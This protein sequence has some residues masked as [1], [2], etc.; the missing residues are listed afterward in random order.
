[1]AEAPPVVSV[2]PTR[3]TLENY[4]TSYMGAYLNTISTERPEHLPPLARSQFHEIE[5]CLMPNGC[6]AMLFSR[7]DKQGVT[8]NERD[9]NY[10]EG[11]VMSG[12]SHLVAVY[13]HEGITVADAISRGKRDASRDVRSLEDSDIAKA[14]SQLEK[15]V[16]GLDEI[17]RQN[18]GTLSAGE[19]ELEKLAP[20]KD[21]L[22]TAGPELDMLAIVDALKN[23]PGVPRELSGQETK[24]V[25]VLEKMA[26]DIGDFENII[27][28][29]EDQDKKL[30]E[31]EKSL[32]KVISEHNRAI[33]ERI[34]K[35]LAVIL[36]ASDKKI[37]KGL[38]VMKS[39]NGAASGQISRD[40]EGRLERVD[41]AVGSLHLQMQELAARK[42]PVLQLPADLEQRLLDLEKG[43]RAS[44][45]K[46]Q[47]ALKKADAA[48]E[49][50]SDKLMVIEELVF[51]VA[52]VKDNIARLNA[53][54]MKI[55][56]FLLQMQTQGV[57]PKQR[58]LR[59]KL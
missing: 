3:K 38:S 11:K 23:Y 13:A 26:H 18:K 49:Q 46:V 20:I 22:I 39:S 55:E 36:Q 58:L 9:W 17:E 1:M 50:P 10:V 40:L 41:K 30:E 27:K 29:V 53:R 43:T 19:K 16:T 15:I 44:E 7:S 32:K 28:Q 47:E 57:A 25:Q 6:F 5:V 33:D 42:P 56:E 35:G 59:R 12:V 48:R 24:E 45:L 21:I 8:V 54:L 37:D 51:T 34:S 52:E 31:I 4:A 14:A 2:V